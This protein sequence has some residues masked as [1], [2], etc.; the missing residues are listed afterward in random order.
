MRSAKRTFAGL[1]ALLLLLGLAGC[2]KAPPTYYYRVSYRPPAIKNASPTGARVGVE[3]PRAE[4]LL[5]QDRIVYFTSGNELNFYQQH[6]WA[7]SPVYMV[8]ALLVR[9]LQ[10]SGLFAEV[11]PFRAQRNLDYV[12]RGR[13]LA[14]EEVDRGSGDIQARFGLSLELIRQEDGQVVWRGQAQR[15][16]PVAVKTV[17]AVVKALDAA[18]A[19]V[20]EELTASLQGEMANLR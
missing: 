9:R 5:R 13:L 4:H 11:A 7:E 16:R 15:Q 18:V 20:L 14:L 19:G 1:S 3:L 6:R 17:E 8:Q 12:L 10:E 2:G